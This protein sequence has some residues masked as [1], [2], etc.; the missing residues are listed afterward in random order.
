MRVMRCICIGWLCLALSGCPSSSQQVKK[1]NP[2]V[3]LRRQLRSSKASV[4]VQ[5]IKEMGQYGEKARPAIPMLHRAMIQDRSSQ[6]RQAALR[7]L[8]DIG[9]VAIP[10]WLVALASRDPEVK[11]IARSG[12]SR[13]SSGDAAQL[14]VSLN[15]PL[16]VVRQA[17][18]SKLK[19][20]GPGAKPALPVLIKHLKDQEVEV[21]EAAAR[22]IG[23]MGPA[24]IKAMDPLVECLIAN[25]A[26]WRV[27]VAV[28]W[29]LG[30]LG[31][32][33]ASTAPQIANLMQDKDSDV[34][35]A[36]MK[37]LIKLGPAVIKPL[38]ETVMDNS[39]QVKLQVAK[40]LGMMGAKGAPGTKILINIIGESDTEVRKHAVISLGKIGPGAAAAVPA[41][42]KLLHT[43]K[44]ER[45][46]WKN[47]VLS[48][49][50][51]GPAGHTA[52]LQAM[53]HKE[54]WWLPP[55]VG[56]MLGELGDKLG[57]PGM[58]LL[59]KTLQSEKWEVRLT[60]TMIVRKL[61]PSAAPLVKTLIQALQDKDDRVK[62][63]VA[64]ALGSIGSQAKSALP[65]LK[66]VL[67][68]K[69]TPAKL[70]TSVQQA[71]QKIKSS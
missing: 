60:T 22:A 28:A 5:A 13:M 29:A 21:R 45:V 59:S 54:L 55:K 52:L 44:E 11:K 24:G 30:E 61:G 67:E 15:S 42:T 31:P 38:S 33:A 3:R 6:V 23:Q 25:K 51:I 34:G 58:P 49:V 43:Q 41:L 71:I 27:R 10:K 20:L 68:D 62:N 17:T 8:Q 47:T 2:M 9:P 26:W 50:R 56:E 16:S 53:Q 19:E 70:K 18:L 46:I 4:R 57:K 35:K 48:L 36:A 1:E 65:A 40:L 64:K 12:L 69:S 66:K 7:A 39:W 37:A 14:A 63:G 32:K